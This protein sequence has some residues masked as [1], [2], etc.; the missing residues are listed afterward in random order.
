MKIVWSAEA[1]ISLT[2]LSRADAEQVESAVQRWASSGEGLTLRVGNEHRLY[3]SS[4]CVLFFVD[5]SA[6]YVDGVRRR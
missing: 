3:V 5:D 2:A 4:Y 6:M 1:L